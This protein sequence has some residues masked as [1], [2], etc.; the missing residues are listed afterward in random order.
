MTRYV[1]IGT[2]PVIDTSVAIGP[3]PFTKTGAVTIELES[4]GYITEVCELLS[5]AEL[6][7]LEDSPPWDGLGEEGG[8]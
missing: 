2:S 7:E 1:V 6:A 8:S 5:L 3:L 4:R